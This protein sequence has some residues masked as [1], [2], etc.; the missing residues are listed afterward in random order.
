MTKTILTQI[1]LF[2]Q[3]FAFGQY[4]KGDK[5]LIEYQGQ[6]FPGKIIETKPEGFYV[7]YDDY[8][9]SWNETLKS[10]RLKKAE[11]G[12]SNPLNETKVLVTETANDPKI[13]ADEMC[14]C[15]KK[16]LKTQKQEDKSRCLKLQEEHVSSLVKGSANYNSY[17]KLVNECEKEITSSQSPPSTATTYEEKVKSV[18]DCFNDAKSGKKQKF[19]CFQLQSTHAKTVGDKNVEFTNQ[20]NKCDN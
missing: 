1:L 13:K 10:D 14:N 17:K 9:A 16:M 11:V 15:L 18:C 19:E 8:D 20:T 2:V 7:S 6:W 12:K 5:V 4:T 3:L